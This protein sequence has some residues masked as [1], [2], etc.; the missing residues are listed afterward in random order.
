MVC[1]S[2][3]TPFCTCLS[4]VKLVSFCYFLTSV[5]LK[6]ALFLLVSVRI[7]YNDEN[8]GI[9]MKKERVERL[10][11][12]LIHQVDNKY[13]EEV[14]MAMDCFLEETYTQE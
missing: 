2:F 3:D 9:K 7:C 11:A 13:H 14:N 5:P 10:F 1:H 12:W 4:A 8:G 6:G